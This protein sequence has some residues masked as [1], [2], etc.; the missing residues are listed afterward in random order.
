[1]RA[2]SSIVDGRSE[3][4]EAPKMNTKYLLKTTGRKEGSTE[5]R[6]SNAIW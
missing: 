6:L 3:G 2:S 1:M 4:I 5:V